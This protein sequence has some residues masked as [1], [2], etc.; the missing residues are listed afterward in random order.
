MIA[1]RRIDFMQRLIG[2]GGTADKPVS[3]D[4]YLVNVL[5]RSRKFQ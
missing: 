2:F 4:R 3:K 5:T 1:R